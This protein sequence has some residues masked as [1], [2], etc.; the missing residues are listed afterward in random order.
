VTRSR[1]LRSRNA[2]VGQT[3]MHCPQLMQDETLRPCVE[4]GADGRLAAAADEVDRA[5]ALDLFAD[6]HAAAAEDALLGVAEQ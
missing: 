3:M 2:P 6:P 1:W 4:C 5:D